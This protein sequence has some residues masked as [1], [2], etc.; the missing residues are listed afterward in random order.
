[1]TKSNRPLNDLRPKAP[2]DG[3]KATVF[4]YLCEYGLPEWADDG[5]WESQAE[6]L[7]AI[8]GWSPGRAKSALELAKTQGYAERK[9]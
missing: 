9:D 6:L 3:H 2:T 5:T 1:M 8:T 4:M 7:S